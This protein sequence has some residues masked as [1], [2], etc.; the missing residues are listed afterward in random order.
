MSERASFVTQHINCPDCQRAAEQVLLAAPP[1]KDFAAWLL[2]H[3]HP[4]EAPHLPIIAGKVGG[5]SE[6][7]EVQELEKRLEVLAPLLCHPLRVVLLPDA[8]GVGSYV[9]QIG[10]AVERLG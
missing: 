2:P 6:Y 5:A 4:V 1:E 8:G 7:E 10:G 9:C 3:W